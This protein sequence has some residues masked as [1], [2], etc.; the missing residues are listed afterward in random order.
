[1][2]GHNEELLRTVLGIVYHSS[3]LSLPLTSVFS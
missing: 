3:S 2:E 1:V